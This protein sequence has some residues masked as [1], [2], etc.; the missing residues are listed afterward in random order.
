MRFRRGLVAPIL[1][2]AAACTA[3]DGDDADSSEGRLVEPG[4]HT[5]WQWYTR[6]Q[7][8]SCELSD[9]GGQ[10]KDAV[11]KSGHNLDIFP[12]E[13]REQLVVTRRNAAGPAFVDAQEIWP[14]L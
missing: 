12:D 8:S 13:A 10:V 4:N 14:A 11:L 9:V 3:G 5:T 2:V 6:S 7:D 1:F